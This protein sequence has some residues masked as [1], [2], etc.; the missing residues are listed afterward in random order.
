MKITIPKDF[1]IYCI[2]GVF[3]TI[4][5][6]SAAF[7]ALNI[8]ACSYITSTIISFT[9]GI[10]VSFI[11][12]KKYTFK[13]SEKNVFRQFFKFVAGFIPVFII[14]FWVLGNNLTYWC[15]AHCDKLIENIC[16]YIPMTPKLLADNT[17]VCVSIGFNLFLGFSMSKF[18]I[19]TKRNQNV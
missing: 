18:I 10:I 12:N 2:V 6:M 5:S 13:D 7:I 17:A 19:F 9:V 3:N 4:A 8:F 14:S 16:Q 15:F 11:L 1:I